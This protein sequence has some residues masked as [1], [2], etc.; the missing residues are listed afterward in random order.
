MSLSSFPNNIDVFSYIQ[1]LPASEYQNMTDFKTLITLPTLTSDQQTQLNSLATHFQSIHVQIKGSDINLID[2]CITNLETLILSTWTGYFAYKGVYNSTIPYNVANSVSFNGLTYISLKQQ[3]GIQPVNDGVNWLQ[4]S[5]N[6]STYSLNIIGTVGSVIYDAT[7]ANPFPTMTPLSCTLIKNGISVTPTSYSWTTPSSNSMLSGSSNS[8]TFTPTIAT[9]F[10]ASS[11]NN[12]I[13]LTVTYDGQTFIEYFVMVLNKIGSTGLSG[14][15]GLGLSYMGNYINTTTYVMGNAVNYNNSIYFCLV[16]NTSVIPTNTTYWNL[17]LSNSGIVIQST[18]PTSPYTNLV[19]VDIST[20]QNLMKYWTG[21][22]WS[23]VSTYNASNIIVADISNL[24]SSTTKNVEN[25]LTEITGAGRTT[26]TIK[27]TSDKIGALSTLTTTD[28]S[29]TVNAINENSNK[30][31]VLNGTGVVVEK[32]NKS[33]LTALQQLV[34]SDSADNLYQLATGTAT[35]ILIT[36][37][38]TLVNGLPITFVANFTDSTTIKTINGKPFYKPGTTTSPSTTVG[39]AYTVWYNLA[40]NCFFIKASAEGTAVVANVLAGQ[41]FSSDEDTGLTGTMPNKVGSN[42]VITPSTVDQEFPKGYYG[43]ALTDGKVKALSVTAGD[44]TVLEDTNQYQ[45]ATNSSTPV[46]YGGTYIAGYSGS[47]RIKFTMKTPDSSYHIY[48]QIYKNGVAVG[49]LQITGITQRQFSQDFSCVAGDC[50]ELYAYSTP[51][52]GSILDIQVCVATQILSDAR[53]ALSTYT[54]SEN[55]KCSDTTTYVDS[56]AIPTNYG[57][58]FTAKIFGTVRV[59]FNQAY[60]SGSPIYAY[61]QIYKNGSPYGSS[62]TQ[63]SLITVT[64][65]IPIKPGDYLE[66]RIWHSFT[67]TSKSSLFEVCYDISKYTEADPTISFV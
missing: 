52:Y 7:G 29:S 42:T 62:V 60:D 17:F 3:T 49:T 26:E 43:G 66:L 51:G 22:T 10:N 63:G 39:K 50:F 28:K 23:Q 48:G 56:S 46:K 2:D 14:L 53:I 64:L 6:G 30:I 24:F 45:P 35:A 19:W 41:T 4:N 18:S 12:T 21:S 59:K 5:T 13:M 44:T 57:K 38:E 32:A 37:A 54:P 65:D 47:I 36:I 61:G 27:N 34:T 31:G 67:T 58:K 1:D 25:I 11:G 40:N 15:N 55:I 9:N 20:S 8:V 33:D 16:G